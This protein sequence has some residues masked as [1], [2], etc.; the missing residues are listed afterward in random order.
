MLLVLAVA[1]DL[2][3]WLRP[4]RR[5]CNRVQYPG[6]CAA[7]LPPPGSYLAAHEVV[8]MLEEAACAILVRLLRRSVGC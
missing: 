7:P 6:R 3:S 8:L 1:V 2:V 4:P 5:P